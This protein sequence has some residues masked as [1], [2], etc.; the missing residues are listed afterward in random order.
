MKEKVNLERKYID[1]S[2]VLS[3]EQL[4]YYIE[5]FLIND[6]K[7]L[8]DVDICCLF[9]NKFKKMNYEQRKSHFNS[10]ISNGARSYILKILVLKH[11]SRILLENSDYYLD[12]YW[13]HQLKKL[14]STIN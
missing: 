11:L 12:I 3:Q 9:D 8:T 7:F 5:T 6:N 14:I 1:D 2:K 10:S 13:Q 4:R